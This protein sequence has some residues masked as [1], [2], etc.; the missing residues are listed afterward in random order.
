MLFVHRYFHSQCALGQLLDSFFVTF[1]PSWTALGHSL[2]TLGTHLGTLGELWGRSWELLDA[3]GALWGRSGACKVHARVFQE[4][5]SAFQELQ[6][7]LRV[8]SKSVLTS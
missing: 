7:G 1:M 8:P 5:P 6:K 4:P 3:L 2:G